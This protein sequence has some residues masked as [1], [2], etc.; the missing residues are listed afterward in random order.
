MDELLDEDDF[1][2][3]EKRLRMTEVPAQPCKTFMHLLTALVRVL[4]AN[5]LFL[6]QVMLGI[7]PTDE[8]FDYVHTTNLSKH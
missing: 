1:H 5:F 3:S 6:S 7:Q 8:L 4:L 2:R